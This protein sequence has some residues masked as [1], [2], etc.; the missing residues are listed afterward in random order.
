MRQ[1]SQVGSNLPVLIYPDKF[2]KNSA[3]LAFGEF[4]AKVRAFSGATGRQVCIV[5]RDE[6]REVHL[7]V[8]DV[9]LSDGKIC[10]V[11]KYGRKDTAR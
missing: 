3:G 6:E 4:D 10:I 9:I 7:P 1:V 5:V 11:A 8:E 2:R